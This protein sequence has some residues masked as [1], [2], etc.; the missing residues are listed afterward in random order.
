MLGCL[1]I[2]WWLSGLAPFRICGHEEMYQGDQSIWVRSGRFAGSGSSCSLPTP[3]HSKKTSQLGVDT[4]VLRARRLWSSPRALEDESALA[5][6]GGPS[7]HRPRAPARLW[8]C[9][10]LALKRP[11]CL[12]AVYA[13]V[14]RLQ[15]YRIGHRNRD[16]GCEARSFV[17]LQ[18]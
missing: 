18:A 12:G 7:F 11:R 5:P 16:G 17:K 10:D 1:Y 3:A 4:R 9:Q 14:K 8:H 15:S 6:C 13:R 2:R